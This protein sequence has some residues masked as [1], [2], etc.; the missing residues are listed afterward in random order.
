MAKQKDIRISNLLVNTE[1][2]R[3]EPLAS[4]KE[5]I[6]NMVE[7][8][9]EK[10]LNLAKHMVEFGLN[11]NDKVQVIASA[12][13]KLK[14]IVLEGNRRVVALKLLLEPTLI[15]GPKQ[16][17]LKSKFTKLHNSSKSK[18]IKEVACTIYDNIDEAN[19][20]IKVKHGGQLDGIG[21][22]D[23]NSMQIQR[24]EER[25]EGKS[26]VVLQAIK[27]VKEA[28]ETPKKIKEN[29][30]KLRITNLDR[31]LGDPDVRSKLGV[32]IKNG[33]LHSGIE[34]KE[35]IKGFNKVIKDLLDPKFK[36]QKI[37]TKAD[38][39]KY[40]DSIKK[41]D[42]PDI[43]KKSSKP[44]QFSSK[45]KSKTRKT[46]TKKPLSTERKTLIPKSCSLSISNPKV[47][48]M[49]YELQKINITKFTN[50]VSVSFRVFIEL[51]VDCYL[52]SNGLIKKP[53]A[54]K[55]GID[56]QQKVF[57]VADH[58]VSKNIA[59]SAIA[60]GMKVAIK[61]KNDLL[62]LDT[63]HAYVHNN[64]FSPT[65]KDMITTWDGIQDFIKLLW[66]NVK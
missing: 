59:D 4:Q 16:K 18:L 29:I 1:N 46:A 62:G 5:A 66:D 56:F 63:W 23:W 44:W 55:S 22:V 15:D 49:Y 38:R 26:S 27:I 41:S 61:K 12:T 57:K 35:V 37:Y 64:R 24:Y 9:G 34:Q 25:V 20:W 17:G 36:V 65:S 42:L 33:V 50:C 28:K 48:T 7:N 31:L 6:D 58:L 19:I 21:T 11:P 54:A 8:Q 39:K 3:F 53:T 14:F 13:A 40:I 60:K 10:L 2:Y 45:T 47:N 52:E 51:S 43:S 30:E 32:E